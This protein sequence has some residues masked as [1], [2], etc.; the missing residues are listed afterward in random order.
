MSMDAAE[1]KRVPLFAALPDEDREELVS[2]ARVTEHTVGDTLA[3]Q[4]GYGHRFHL[5]LEGSG[6]VRRDEIEVARVGPGDFVGEIALLGGG[7]ATATVTCTMPTRCLTLARE[8]FY[9]VLQ[10]HP[11]IALRILEVVC[12]RISQETLTA[13][14]NLA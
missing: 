12:R 14:G 1:L 4:G 9:E 2:A 5:I 11:A 3:D 10:A 8:P 13:T 6:V 7:H